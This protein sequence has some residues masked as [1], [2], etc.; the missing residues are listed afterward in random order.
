[1]PDNPGTIDVLERIAAAL[2]DIADALDDV[3]TGGL[4]I[5]VGKDFE[6]N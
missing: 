3:K 1:M 2:E 6:E 5:Y 4:T